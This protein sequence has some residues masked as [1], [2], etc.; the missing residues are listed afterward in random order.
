MISIKVFRLI[1]VC[2]LALMLATPAARAQRKKQLAVLDFDF[3]TVDIGLARRAYGTNQNLARR[4][5]DKLINSLVALKTC[6]VVERS[7]LEKVLR[8]QN[9]GLDGRIDPSTAAK[10]GRILGVDALIIG[11]VS[12]FELRGLPNNNRDTMWD[13]KDMFARIAVNFRI[14]D[15]TTGVVDVSN[16]MIGT[17]GQ[18]AKKS[19]GERFGKSILD[20]VIKGNQ[21]PQVKDEQIRDVVGQALDEVIGNMTNDVQKYLSGT[22]RPPEPTIT[23]DK[24]INGRVVSVNG[25][26]LIVTNVNKSAVRVGD[27]LFVRRFKTIRDPT[28]NQNI[29]F[30]EKIGEVEVVEIQDQAIIGSFAG[31]G[32]AQVGDTVT[33]SPTGAGITGTPVRSDTKSSSPPPANTPTPAPVRAKQEQTITVP[34]KAGWFDTKLDIP[35]GTIVEFSAE[36][37]VQLNQTAASLPGGIPGRVRSPRLPLPTAPVGALVAKFQYSSGKASTPVFIGAQGKAQTATESG[38]LWLSVNDDTPADNN[39]SFT[40]KVRW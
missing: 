9:M 20:G 4:V 23:S 6:Q 37:A 22:L 26:S 28:T 25:P 5:A 2:L 12:V 17:S 40:V 18:G 29:S 10:V 8:E 31:S 16:E 34:G 36:G 14:V 15:T 13:P 7:Q 35:P 33:N 32:V 27:R 19:V 38:R 24:L 39:G 3:A 30:S 1:A 21:G 11:T